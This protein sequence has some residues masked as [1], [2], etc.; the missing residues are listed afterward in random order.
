MVRSI[1]HGGRNEPVLEAL[2]RLAPLSAPQSLHPVTREIIL[3]GAKPSAADAFAAFY[4]LEELRRVAEHTFRQAD[5]MMLPTTPTLYT[6][7]QVRADPYQLNSRLGTYTNFV[8]LLD[9]CA[10]A[11][12]NGIA[13]DLPTSLQIIGRG[14]D[15]ETV[16]RVEKAL[17]VRTRAIE[18][19]QPNKDG[20]GWEAVWVGGRQ[21]RKA[22]VTG[23]LA[24]ANHRKEAVPMVIRS[25]SG[26]HGAGL[27]PVRT[28]RDAAGEA[29]P[30]A[31]RCRLRRFNR[32]RNLG[33]LRR[34]LR[35]FCCSGTAAIVD[36]D[37]AIVGRRRGQGFPGRGRGNRRGA[38][39]I[40]FRRLAPPLWEPV[41]HSSRST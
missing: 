37:G 39:H 6:V 38:R 19:E 21:Y 32:G 22:T 3:G 30:A 7:E 20:G 13:N 5:V 8:N 35:P 26:R 15:E 1:R 9:L 41:S 10:L 25:P 40:G 18:T 27:S 31:G 11:V 24:V 34:G 36:R 23:E 29:R 16:L 17:S 28:R 12:P 4:Q 14:Y 2:E 33:A